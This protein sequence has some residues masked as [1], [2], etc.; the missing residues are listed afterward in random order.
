MNDQF[1]DGITVQKNTLLLLIG[2]A[3][4]LL[5]GASI[6]AGSAG[7]TGQT[8]DMA[9]G[10]EN[11][12]QAVAGNTAATAQTSE[13]VQTEEQSG[14]TQDIYIRALNNGQYDREEIT[15][16]KGTMV[17]LH[18]TA[19]SDA[20]CGR[21]LV[22]YGLGVKAYSKNG[23]EAVVEFTPKDAGTYEYSC[24]MRMWGPGRLVV[25]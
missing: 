3:L 22:I 9:L 1:K 19:D 6:A 24:G 25:A 15:V 23:E 18:F 17:R 20:G 8:A 16:R 7:Q 12:N 4:A 11:A 14:S 2:L 5:V 10:K 21:Q 13:A